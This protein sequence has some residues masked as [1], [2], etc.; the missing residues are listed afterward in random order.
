[1]AG[2]S[3]SDALAVARELGYKPRLAFKAAEA[4]AIIGISPT[5]VYKLI[6]SGQLAVRRLAGHDK[7]GAVIPYQEIDKWIRGGGAE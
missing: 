3:D 4:A 5:Q 7:R 6:D 1:M 2:F